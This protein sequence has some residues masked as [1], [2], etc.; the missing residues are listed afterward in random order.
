MS[1]EAPQREQQEQKIRIEVGERQS[2]FDRI[3]KGAGIVA[4]GALVAVGVGVVREVRD[5]FNGPS[6]SMPD[7]NLDLGA[8]NDRDVHPLVVDPES[9]VRHELRGVEG[10]GGAERLEE[11][12]EASKKYTGKYFWGLNDETIHLRDS[13]FMLEQSIKG[14]AEKIEQEGREIKIYL[15]SAT[16]SLYEY[17]LDGDKE[18]EAFEAAKL[19]SPPRDS[20][21]RGAMTATIQAFASTTSRRAA[22]KELMVYATADQA[23]DRELMEGATCMGIHTAANLAADVLRAEGQTVIIGT[24]PKYIDPMTQDPEQYLGTTYINV[25]ANMPPRSDVVG[26]MAPLT[27][28]SCRGMVEE[29]TSRSGTSDKGALETRQIEKLELQ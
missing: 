28:D 15:N 12:G 21:D 14:P 24:E 5:L 6:V 23:A 1:V 4:V 19:V 13:A 8:L 2:F 9:I 10:F 7:V 16:P 29:M 26:P 20:N 3:K 17:D 22:L 18:E 25:I 27:Y 11:I